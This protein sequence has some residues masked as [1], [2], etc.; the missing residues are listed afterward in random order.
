MSQQYLCFLIN[1]GAKDRS[2]SRKATTEL[3]AIKR[4][5]KEKEIYNGTTT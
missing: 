2:V 5:T 3:A 1:K 4:L